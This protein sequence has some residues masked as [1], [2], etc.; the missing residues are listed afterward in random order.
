MKVSTTTDGKTFTLT[1]ENDQD[2]QFI[3]AVD[4]QG[5]LYVEKVERTANRNEHGAFQNVSVVLRV[6][7]KCEQALRDQSGSKALSALREVLRLG[8]GEQ[9]NDLVTR[10][11]RL[12]SNLQPQ[13][14][15]ATT[16]EQLHT[17]LQALRVVVV[18]QETV[19]NKLVR[20]HGNPPVEKTAIVAE[21][22]AA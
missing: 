18:K 4:F 2:H 13:E 19:I 17:M 14:Q 9:T 8:L 11:I 6:D 21:G 20:T 16:L 10:L 22:G 1:R 12:E 7:G 3:D 5:R 15:L